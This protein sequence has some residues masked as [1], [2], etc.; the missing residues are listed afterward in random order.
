M[1]KLRKTWRSKDYATSLTCKIGSSTWQPRTLSRE[2]SR[3]KTIERYF[4]QWTSTTASR[5]AIFLNSMSSKHLMSFKTRARSRWA[6]LASYLR[7]IL[8]ASEMLSQRSLNKTLRE[9]MW[10]FLFSIMQNS[11]LSSRSLIYKHS[12]LLSQLKFKHLAW[13]SGCPRYK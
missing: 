4:W 7:I 10:L 12:L 11:W 3:Q 6:W 9:L 13:V 8:D 1:E 5:T 2:A